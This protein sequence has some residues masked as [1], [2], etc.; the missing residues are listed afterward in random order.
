M[1]REPPTTDP[2]TI[3]AIA[4]PERPLLDDLFVLAADVAV[5]VEVAVAVVTWPAILEETISGSSIETLKHG[6]SVVNELK[7]TYVISEQA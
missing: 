4:P 7:G 3:P 1:I 2:T 5:A 6:I